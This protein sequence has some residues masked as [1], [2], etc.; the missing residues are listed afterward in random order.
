[1]GRGV[2]YAGAPLA[3]SLPAFI[4]SRMTYRN[5]DDAIPRA[6]PMLKR[7]LL[8]ALCAALALL[9][10]RRPRPVSLRG[11]VV[12]LTGASSGIGRAAAFI[13]AEHGAH[14]VLVAR[15][16]RELETLRDELARSG[17]RVLVCP[18]DLTL[19]ADAQRAVQQALAA[20]GR[21]D[22]LVNNAGLTNSGPFHRMDP[23]AIHSLTAINLQ[24][25]L[26][27]IHLILPTMLERGSG[28]IVNVGS[29]A[30]LFIPPGM[31]AYA[32][33]KAGLL[34]FDDAL[35]RELAG[36]GVH[37]SSV[38]PGWT[39]TDMIAPLDRQAMRR[40]GLLRRGVQM[41]SA[42]QVADA[43]VDAVRYR[44]RRVVLGGPLLA[45]AAQPDLL[46]RSLLDLFY[47]RGTNRKRWMQTL[48]DAHLH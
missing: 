34:A 20:F 41:Q 7:L 35:A 13:F 6:L 1:M 36:T 24:A 31:A 29:T 25:P 48:H 37:V 2:F 14:L 40:A 30:G 26:R 44:R 16:T 22:V 3:N 42:Q 10:W 15:R 18:A 5:N 9:L 17:A 12:L 38:L 47:R 19:E 46:L 27:L 21:V 28:H 11:S 43:V 33:T 45:A 4:L 23:A 8:P 32:T 39:D